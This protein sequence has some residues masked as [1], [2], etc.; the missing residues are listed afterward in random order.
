[1]VALFR[2][3]TFET[4]GIPWDRQRVIAELNFGELI[5]TWAER[6]EGVPNAAGL[7]INKEGENEES[8]W[9]YTRKLLLVILN[10]WEVKIAPKIAADTRKSGGQG[11]EENTAMDTTKTPGQQ[12]ME[13]DFAVAN[14]DLLDDVWMKDILGGGYE[15]FRDPYF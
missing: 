5:R 2:L 7:D 14:L 11:T 4:P 13:M 10:W 8:P 1:M 3:S 12:P 6:W 15:F 9:C